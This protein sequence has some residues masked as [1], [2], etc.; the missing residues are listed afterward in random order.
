[1]RCAREEREVSTSRGGA[2][3]GE[4]SVEIQAAGSARP[5]QSTSATGGIFY[6]EENAL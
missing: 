1:M 5:I 6:S 2:E 3:L 4:D